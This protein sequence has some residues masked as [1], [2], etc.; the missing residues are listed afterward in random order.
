LV[1][2]GAHNPNCANEAGASVRLTPQPSPVYWRRAGAVFFLQSHLSTITPLGVILE[3]T[4]VAHRQ[5]ARRR[6]GLF[7]SRLR[8]RPPCVL[9]PGARFLYGSWHSERAA[10]LLSFVRRTVPRFYWL[11][12]ALTSRRLLPRPATTIGYVRYYTRRCA[13]GEMLPRAT[14][15]IV[16]KTTTA[17]SY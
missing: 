11:G 7:F 6:R 15:C 2:I 1:T 16:V 17:A 4:G 14:H 10:I 9:F 8:R 13:G 12:G 5:H 3:S